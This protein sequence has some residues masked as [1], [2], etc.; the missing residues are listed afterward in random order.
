M[1]TLQH[2]QEQL[3]KAFLT[4]TAA[5]AGLNLKWAGGN[6]YG[7]DGALHEVD[8]IGTERIESGFSLDVQLKAT[9]RWTSRN[10]QI[11][12]DLDVRTHNMLVRRALSS[13][14][15][16]AILVLLCLPK[17]EASWTCFKEPRLILKR[18]CYWYAISGGESDNQTTVRVRVPRENVVT[19][20]LLSTLI[21]M[22][23][24]GE[25]LT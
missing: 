11:I 5:R 24:R 23:R 1:I 22:I 3:S 9:T 21:G 17:N 10:G 4:A 6:D 25:A 16:P 8:I 15:T 19:P 13:G 12:Y 2:T 20:E 14:A 7:I 18:C